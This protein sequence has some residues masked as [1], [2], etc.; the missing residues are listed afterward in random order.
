MRWT[1]VGLTDESLVP[2]MTRNSLHGDNLKD[3]VTDSENVCP[4]RTL[5]DLTCRPL[6]F[7]SQL[8]NRDPM[9]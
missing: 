3:I 9:R 2:Y 6:P 1:Q 4:L 8:R 7:F 5:K